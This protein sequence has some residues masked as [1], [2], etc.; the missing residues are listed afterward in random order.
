M[1]ITTSIKNLLTAIA[2]N[3]PVS[4]AAAAAIVATSA[5]AVHHGAD[6][7]LPAL[8]GPATAALL[9]FEWLQWTALG[10]LAAI[11]AAGDDNRAAILKAMSLGIGALQVGLYTFSTVAIAGEAGAHW[12]TGW[13]LGAVILGA[14]IYAGLSFV[15][16][17]AS[18]DAL[19]GRGRGPTGG[20]RASIH[21]AIF[22]APPALPDL[23]RE[24]VVEF[25]L[26]KAIRTKMLE[27][28]EAADE[29][30]RATGEAGFTKQRARRTSNR[31]RMRAARAA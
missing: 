20:S 13:A 14:C 9:G 1:D 8:A 6:V 15:A 11:E 30:Q 10:R 18:C 31:L 3:R 26:E 27:E 25:D 28:K 12:S 29:C 24:N 5:V 7:A 17:Y 2:S 19:E 4:H 21:T 16:K 23:S 22:E